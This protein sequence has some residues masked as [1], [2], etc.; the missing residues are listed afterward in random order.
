MIGFERDG[1]QVQA[2]YRTTSGAG[3]STKSRRRKVVELTRTGLERALEALEGRVNVVG[4]RGY[5]V[6]E[7]TLSAD[8]RAA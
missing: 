3:P 6:R 8:G 4:T 5:E 7:D 1:I 2:L